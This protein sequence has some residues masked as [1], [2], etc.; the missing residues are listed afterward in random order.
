MNIPY[1]LFNS[2]SS[3]SYLTLPY[4]SPFTYTLSSVYIAHERAYTNRIFDTPSSSF[5]EKIFKN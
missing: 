2:A 4:R 1:D 5:R 3:Q